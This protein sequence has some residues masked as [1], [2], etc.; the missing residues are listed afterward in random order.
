L[1]LS[2]L[3]RRNTALICYLRESCSDII[4]DPPPRFV[5]ARDGLA[6]EAKQATHIGPAGDIEVFSNI[7]NGIKRDPHRI[8]RAN[9]LKL[10]WDASRCLAMNKR[11][12]NLIE[13]G[14]LTRPS[15]EV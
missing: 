6:H 14:L 9:L 13:T 10:Q 4:V 8:V 1:P 7:Q 12:A 3:C 2:V 11:V 5:C 15:E